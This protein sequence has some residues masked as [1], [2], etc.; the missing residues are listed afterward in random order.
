MGLQLTHHDMNWVYSLH[1]LKGNG[2]YLKTRQP[3]GVPLVGSSSRPQVKEEEESTEKEEK[4]VELVSSEDE[5]EVFNQASPSEAPVKADISFA[6]TLLEEDMGI[7]RKK[8]TSLLELIESQPGKEAPGR[9]SQ[10]RPLSPSQ[11]KLPPALT[12]LPPPPKSTQ[13]PRTEPSDPKRKKESK[14]KEGLLRRHRQPC[15]RCFGED[16][17]TALRHGLIAKFQEAG[18]YLGHVQSK[19]NGQQRQQATPPANPQAPPAEKE[20][21]GNVELASDPLKTA[22]V[23]QASKASEIASQHP[24]K[25]KL[26][27][28]LKK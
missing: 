12:K 14:G 7:Q 24:P 22:P 26:T 11:S 15:G 9:S 10:R 28:K 18:G 8:H 27:I 20:A 6:D 25:D 2:Y 1:N 16:L 23:S 13:P 19:G 17:T 21:S 4:I 5:F 3:K